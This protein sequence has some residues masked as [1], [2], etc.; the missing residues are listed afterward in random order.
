VTHATFALV[1][2]GLAEIPAGGRLL[3]ELGRGPV[4]SAPTALLLDAAR[5]ASDPAS[6][7]TAANISEA[8]RIALGLR[9]GPTV[10]FLG[11]GGDDVSAS[12]RT[13]FLTPFGD[14]MLSPPALASTAFVWGL[15]VTSRPGLC[16]PLAI[17]DAFIEAD[18]AHVPAVLLARTD[19]RAVEALARTRVLLV[20]AAP[21]GVG[22]GAQ[23]ASLA[24][25]LSA[26]PYTPPV[27]A[28]TA[29]A[30]SAD[31]FQRVSLSASVAA[32]ASPSS[33]PDDLL[34]TLTVAAPTPGSGEES[35]PVPSAF[36]RPAVNI[37][38]QA[39]ADAVRAA[40]A[41]LA[42]MPPAIVEGGPGASWLV[43]YLVP[44]AFPAF[45]C[46]PRKPGGVG[47]GG[48][49]DA[50]RARGPRARR[51]RP[52][53]RAAGRGGHHSCRRERGGGGGGAAAPPRPLA[54]ASGDN[55]APRAASRVD[56]RGECDVAR[57]LRRRTL[58]RQPVRP[59]RLC[60]R[61]LP[62]DGDGRRSRRGCRG[63]GHAIFL[64]ARLLHLPRRERRRHRRRR[65][66][67]HPDRVCK[68]HR[69]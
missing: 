10:T 43:T 18:P 57:Q 11:R 54:P 37:S 3:V 34:L 68:R 69:R 66:H 36:A 47:H 63:P 4:S 19:A 5:L 56:G 44:G 59:V 62:L 32:A 7:A 50:R 26:P 8:A 38:A 13:H 55:N 42:G 25:E 52:C 31:R 49:G 15:V 46:S 41:T 39:T 1:L 16:P 58:G 45:G 27:L 53:S 24:L 29:S 35:W 48:R 61:R 64:C 17:A 65:Q 22:D 30:V 21:G 40:L 9:V 6:A 20:T 23:Q 12:D 28:I 2:D 67:R 14:E 60:G 33:S 51:I